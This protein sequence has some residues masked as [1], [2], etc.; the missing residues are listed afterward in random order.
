MKSPFIIL[1]IGRCLHQQ[2]R[3]KQKKE[4]QREVRSMKQH[5]TERD[6]KEGKELMQILENLTEEGRKQVVIYAS[7][8][9]DRQ[10][11]EELGKKAG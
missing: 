3:R 7:A 5:L 9:K 4:Q 6:L 1:G 10:I 11:L 2:Y 8:L